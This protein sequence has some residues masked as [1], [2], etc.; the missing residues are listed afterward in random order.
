[1][2]VIEFTAAVG[3]Y[4]IA[5]RASVTSWWR[6]RAHNTAVAG[7]H[8]SPHLVGLAVDVIYDA[9]GRPAG[10]VNLARNLGLTLLAEDDHDHLQPA[11]WLPI[12]AA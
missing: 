2:N 8:W 12:P 7:V 6:T 5:T 9:P 1:M 3:A 4:S 11:G 10:A